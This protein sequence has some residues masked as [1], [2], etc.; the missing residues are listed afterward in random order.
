MRVRWVKFGSSLVGVQSITDLVITAFIQRAQVVPNL[1]NV[2]VQS[3]GPGVCIECVA[4]LVDLVVEY[5]NGAPEGRVS[6]IPVNGL[7]VGFIRL[8]VLLLG[9][10]ATA[11]QVPALSI[12]VVGTN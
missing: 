7:L 5:T 6:T 11:K 10:V 1:A 12:I 8:G 2:R 9:H 4:V 3:D